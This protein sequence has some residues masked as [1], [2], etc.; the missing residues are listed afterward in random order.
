MR[1]NEQKDAGAEHE[2]AKADGKNRRPAHALFSG[3][4]FKFADSV[5]GE[6][7]N[8]VSVHPAF[9]V[10]FPGHDSP[11]CDYASKVLQASE[12]KHPI[13][14]ISCTG[15]RDLYLQQSQRVTGGQQSGDRTH[16]YRAR[17]IMSREDEPW[18][19]NT[20]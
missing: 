4:V 5:H 13:E 18:R 14:R 8:Q 7:I 9:E 1:G 20:S 3:A 19:L 15:L 2:S 11:V 12:L 10:F 16:A 6:R 17:L